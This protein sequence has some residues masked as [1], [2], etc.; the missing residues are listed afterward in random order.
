MTKKEGKANNFILSRSIAHTV[1]RRAESLIYLLSYI[2]M[3][4]NNG[5]TDLEPTITVI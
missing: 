5:L 3:K 1:A 4:K 2:I